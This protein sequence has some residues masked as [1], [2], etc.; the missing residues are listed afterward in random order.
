MS[1]IVLGLTYDAIG[2]EVGLSKENAKKHVEAL[3]ARL[4]VTLPRKRT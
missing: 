2:R 1:R 4:G 3:A